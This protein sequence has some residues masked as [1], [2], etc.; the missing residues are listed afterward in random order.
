MV[1]KKTE[2]GA[3]LCAVSGALITVHGPTDNH[4]GVNLCGAKGAIA[5][6]GQTRKGSMMKNLCLLILIAAIVFAVGFAGYK[7][8][9][10]RS[11]QNEHGSDEEEVDVQKDG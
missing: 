3:S 10:A 6:A 9:N 1:W 11:D 5:G 4:L 2:V 8:M 7:A